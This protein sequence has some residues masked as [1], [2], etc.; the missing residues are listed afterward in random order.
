MRNVIIGV[1]L[2][3]VAVSFMLFAKHRIDQRF[4]VNGYHESSVVVSGSGQ[5]FI[6]KMVLNVRAVD[7]EIMRERQILIHHYQRFKAGK[8]PGRLEVA[9]LQVLAYQYGLPKV[10]YTQDGHWIDVIERVDIIPLSLVIAQ[11]INESDWGRSRFARLGNNYFGKWCY[12]PGCG[13]VPLRRPARATYEVKSYVNMGSSIHDYLLNLNSHKA[14]QQLRD[15][16]A[17]MRKRNQDLTGYALAAGLVNYSQ[18][19]Q[20]YVGIIQGLIKH[21]HL[22]KYDKLSGR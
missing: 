8:S 16:R 13:F 22:D 1:V 18:R 10:D 14:Y 15:I 9:W 7:R 5:V 11:A 17:S 4:L 12:K 6:D 19:R 3:V 2:A 21:F 20:E